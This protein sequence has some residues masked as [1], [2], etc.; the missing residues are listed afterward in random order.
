MNILLFL[1]TA[2]N[3]HAG[4][5]QRSTYKMCKLFSQMGHKPFV[6]EVNGANKERN[7]DDIHIFSIRDISSAK[8]KKALLEIYE[9]YEVALVINQVGYSIKVL[10]FLRYHAK[11][12]VRIVST[13][14]M[15]PLNF[16]DNMEHILTSHRNA[17]FRRFGNNTFVRS[18]I[19]LYHRLKQHIILKRIIL[20]SDV[21]L[22]LS[23]G[24]INELKWF[25]LDSE[26]LQQKVRVIPNVF[27]EVAPVN[28]AAKE[29]LCLFVGRLERSQKRTDLLGH[30]WT[31]L[32][33]RLPNWRFVIIGDGSDK[34][35]LETYFIESGL[36]NRIEIL[37]KKDPT[38]YYQKAKILSFTSAYE[39]FGNVLIEAQQHGV[40]PIL[41]NSYS[42]APHLVKQ[43]AT[44]IL[45]NP[46]DIDRFIEASYFL[47]NNENERIRM[48]LNGIQNA[49][50]FEFNSVSTDW[51]SLFLELGL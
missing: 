5:V 17:I 45:V 24:F 48:M 35:W 8:S 26:L 40:V 49:K 27:S 50:R 4:G 7:M 3:R 46:F 16:R 23:P 34:D 14:R 12:D 15:N 28:V 31:E 38:Q 20:G 19:L 51:Q 18:M 41:F 43:D 33:R 2:L 36:E 10:Q 6:L 22:V 32:A 9:R 30:I 25:K 29:N 13:L 39:G 21:F 11:S 47:A 1:D 44:G 42:A 37:G